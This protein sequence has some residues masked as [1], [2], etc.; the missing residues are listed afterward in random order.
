MK[1]FIPILFL[2]LA[3]SCATSKRCNAKYPCVVKDSVIVKIRDVE[4][5]VTVTDTM[6]VTNW[7]QSPCDSITGKVK[8]GYTSTSGRTTI[9]ENNGGLAVS[10]N[11]TGLSVKA[12]V[13]DTCISK[14]TT[15][16]A[17]CDSNHQ[18]GF[19]T[20]LIWSGGILWVVLLIAG[21]IFVIKR[22]PV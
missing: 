16:R 5:V 6:K 20:F 7:L 22:L 21:L 19:E 1:L 15:V 8:K 12:M 13:R 10:T 3:I 9:K 2:I 11:I 14:F 17:Q 4:R 18:T